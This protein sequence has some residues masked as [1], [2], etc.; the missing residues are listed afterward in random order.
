MHSHD[1]EPG[2]EPEIATGTLAEIYAQQG[3]YERALEIY[4]RIQ[5]QRPGDPRVA[6]RIAEL[7]EAA[8]RG[9][10]DVEVAIPPEGRDE[11]GE[12]SERAEPA[13][14]P[15]EEMAA[16]TGPPQEEEATKEEPPSRSPDVESDAAFEDW[17]AR[18]AR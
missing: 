18:R 14:P 11:N 12:E 15:L 17:L 1:R 7:V 4:R 8:E 3:L 13:G 6:E 5:H 9:E 16:R 10:E 2:R